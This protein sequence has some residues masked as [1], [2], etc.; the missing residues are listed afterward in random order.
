MF[1]AVPLCSLFYFF[2][3]RHVGGSEKAVSKLECHML[4]DFEYDRDNM[5][6][7]SM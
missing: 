5:K 6:S 7:I 3:P 4:Q 2:L 1:D